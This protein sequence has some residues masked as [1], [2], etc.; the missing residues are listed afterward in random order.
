MEIKPALLV[1]RQTRQTL[2]QRKAVKHSVGGPV[3]KREEA[4]SRKACTGPVL[5]TNE[6]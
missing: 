1:V 5:F 2:R 6:S 3:P 4:I